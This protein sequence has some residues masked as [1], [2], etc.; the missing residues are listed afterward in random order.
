[1]TRE[2]YEARWKDYYEVLQVHAKAEQPI[3]SAAFRKL[4]QLYHPDRN[5]NADATD[6]FK[7]INEAY[8]VLSN[9][10][11]RKTYDAVCLTR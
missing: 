8:E 6:R 4:A 10:D 9:P 7:E 2:Q 11:R 5:K 3:I 1:M